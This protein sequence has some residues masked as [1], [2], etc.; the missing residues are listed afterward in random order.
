MAHS[1]RP[2]GPGFNG[3]KIGFS[4]HEARELAK[5]VDTKSQ[6]AAKQFCDALISAPP[7]NPN[8]EELEIVDRFSSVNLGAGVEYM[9]T[10]NVF[11]GAS[12]VTETIN[13]N[14]PGDTLEW[15]GVLELIDK[16]TSATGEHL[17][18]AMRGLISD[19]EV[20]DFFNRN[21]RNRKRRWIPAI[22]SNNGAVGH[23]MKFCPDRTRVWAAGIVHSTE[24][25]GNQAYDKTV[26]VTAGPAGPALEEDDPAMYTNVAI[27]IGWTDIDNVHARKDPEMSLAR[28]SIVFAPKKVVSVV[29]ERS[30][31]PVE[32]CNKKVV[33]TNTTFY[34]EH[35]GM[36]NIRVEAL[37]EWCQLK[38]VDMGGKVLLEVDVGTVMS[39][40]LANNIKPYY[41]R[42][43][44]ATIPKRIRHFQ[45]DE[46]EPFDWDK[47]VPRHVLEDFILE[48]IT[49]TS[50]NYILADLVYMLTIQAWY[51]HGLFGAVKPEEPIFDMHDTAHRAAFMH[52]FGSPTWFNMSDDW[53]TRTLVKSEALEAASG[54]G[55]INDTVE[56]AKRMVFAFYNTM[57]GV[58]PL[59]NSVSSEMDE[60][61]VIRLTA[62]LLYLLEALF[63]SMSK[64]PIPPDAVQRDD[65][66]GCEVPRYKLLESVRRI[67][68]R[69]IE[70]SEQAKKDVM[71]IID[72]IS[73]R[74]VPGV[75]LDAL[76]TLHH[77]G[78]TAVAEIKFPFDTLESY[79]DFDLSELLQTPNNEYNTAMAELL[80]NIGAYQYVTGYAR[81]GKKISQ[82]TTGVAAMKKNYRKLYSQGMEVDE[83]DVRWK[84]VR[85]SVRLGGA[86]FAGFTV[87]CHN[88]SRQTADGT[89]PGPVKPKER[90]PPATFTARESVYTKEDEDRII[91]FTNLAKRWNMDVANIDSVLD[92]ALLHRLNLYLYMKADPEVLKKWTGYVDLRDSI[93]R[94][95]WPDVLRNEY[96][97]TEIS[98][99]KKEKELM[100]I[101][102][103]LPESMFKVHRGMRLLTLGGETRYMGSSS[104][105][106]IWT[107][108]VIK[109]RGVFNY[110]QEQAC[111]SSIVTGRVGN[112]SVMNHYGYL[113][114]AGSMEEPMTFDPNGVS[115]GKMTEFDKWQLTVP[116]PENSSV[117]AE[118]T[119]TK[120]LSIQ[121]DAF[122]VFRGKEEEIHTEAL[123]KG[124][125]PNP[126]PL[127]KPQFTNIGGCFHASRFPPESFCG[128]GFEYGKYYRLFELSLDVG[129]FE[130]PS[131]QNF[132]VNIGPSWMYQQ[133][134]HGFV[135]EP[136]VV[137]YELFNWWSADSIDANDSFHQAFDGFH[138]VMKKRAAYAD[139][140]TQN[141]ASDSGGRDEAARAAFAQTQAGVM[142][143]VAKGTSNQGFPPINTGMPAQVAPFP[144]SALSGV[145]GDA[146][147][148]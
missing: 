104:L 112:M 31:P 27:Q 70:Q 48:E 88:H 37:N 43:P 131:V 120:Q 140:P 116:G 20:T 3:A 47:T 59:Y 134:T 14:Q 107:R 84:G 53:S 62:D 108:Y 77:F 119:E 123:R 133:D 29:M 5:D 125:P 126:P 56:N 22:K 93:H 132:S 32:L 71:K 67:V 75:G 74:Y 12:A 18:K 50:V 80:D 117:Y 103:L 141:T 118:N 33:L 28:Y 102:P 36:S 139:P 4:A 138:D 6:L 86:V 114:A 72:K 121:Q 83:L 129:M 45:F 40:F 13:M 39:I 73:A 46:S 87:V 113:G 124:P 128:I 127:G 97:V 142:G 10:C 30:Q 2:D 147:Q 76:E 137:E 68:N 8:L 90:P 64:D 145:R 7:F 42:H 1:K 49:R 66:L 95:E 89:V 92:R 41:Q 61:A 100:T 130:N 57:I 81:P 55:K 82:P 38:R 25:L 19:D 91:H 9:Y 16:A 52:L 15:L 144:A 60:G 51:L 85:H 135:T 54:M 24:T 148:G 109:H 21:D 101:A 35:E 110:W 122:W 143:K 111:I 58:W 94:Y 106:A 105:P 17:N 26:Y 63:R 65:Q 98:A 79:V 136:R 11:N 69:S 96:A 44:V 23:F 78:P 99:F 34:L 115:I 146:M